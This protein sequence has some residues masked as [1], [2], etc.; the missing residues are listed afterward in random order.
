MKRSLTALTL[1][2]CFL[3][4]LV[5]TPAVQ[6]QSGLVITDSSVTVDFPAGIDFTVSAQSSADIAD[7][8]LS[9][10]VDRRSHARIVSEIYVTVSPSTNVEASWTWDTRMTGGMPPGTGI[11]YWWTVKDTDG[12][13]V[14][15]VPETVVMNDN[16]YDWR[17]LE[18][19]MVT[20][21]WYDGEESFARELME[22]TQDALIRLADTAGAELESP[23]A[24]YIYA[25]AAD[26]RGALVYPQ[27]WTGGV[28]FT[29][30]GTIAIGIGTGNLAWGKRT[31]AHELT[32]LVTHQVVYNPLG[33]MPTWLDEGLAMYGEG[34]LTDNFVI[35]FDNAKI[36]G[37]LIGVRSLAS[38][39]SAYSDQSYLAYAQS[40]YI[41]EYLI[42]T[43]G[44]DKMLEL[45]DTFASG[46]G[47]DEALEIVYG[48]DMDGL[49]SE[50]LTS[51]EGVP[52]G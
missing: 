36:T 39:F 34:E 16:R 31:I 14:E 32:H 35:T 42:D 27:E 8:R 7:V 50:W 46:A 26:L 13:V 21:Y 19:G 47:Y 30:H 28:A 2:I 23:V 6:A 40:Y 43:Y 41:V 49:N 37:N 22:A 29:E 10:V 25:D 4:C 24:L 17:T 44:R 45:L 3:V 11:E 51:L 15:T 9:Y 20:L 5:F 33:G 1:V 52:A 18:E 38:P 12:Q 48:F